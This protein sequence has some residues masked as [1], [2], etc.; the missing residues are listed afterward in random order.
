LANHL[1]HNIYG[2][3]QRDESFSKPDAF[4]KHSAAE[5]L[6][7]AKFDAFV[8][9]WLF[10]RDKPETTTGDHK[11]KKL[12]TVE[13]MAFFAPSV[14]HKVMQRTSRVKKRKILD[15]YKTA[16]ESDVEL[17]L[18]KVWIFYIGRRVEH[19]RKSRKYRLA[20][21]LSNLITT[22]SSNPQDSNLNGSGH[23]RSVPDGTS[24]ESNRGEGI[25]LESASRAVPAASVLSKESNS[26]PPVTDNERQSAVPSSE[27]CQE[28]QSIDSS[29]KSQSKESLEQSAPS[30]TS[31]TVESIS[32]KRARSPQLDL[33]EPENQIP[34]NAT[35]SSKRQ[36]VSLSLD[37]VT[38]GILDTLWNNQKLDAESLVQYAIQKAVE[39][40]MN[41]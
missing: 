32:L 38:R 9:R 13:Y 2:F 26:K 40:Q 21:I 5:Q 27:A 34:E 19:I 3:L 36:K 18:K 29:E 1:A 30:A 15:E 22:P 28:S 17:W 12:S 16:K 20:G 10:A 4:G 11:P 7:D 33:S 23:G 37:A 14:E 31:N 6:S 8:E 41:H 24:G 25:K 39:S 35:S